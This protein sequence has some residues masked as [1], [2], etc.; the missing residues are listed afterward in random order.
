MRSLNYRSGTSSPAGVE[1]G[2]TFSDLRDRAEKVDSARSVAPEQISRLLQELQS[3]QEIRGM[4]MAALSDGDRI[5]AAASDVGRHNA[6]DK[7]WGY[8]LLHDVAAQ[9]QILL[10]TGRI[11]SEMLGKAARMGVPVVASRTSPTSLAVQLAVAWNVTLVGYV[12][13]ESMNV[14]A[15]ASRI[16]SAQDSLAPI[17]KNEEVRTNAN[18]R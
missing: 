3:D 15:G 4:H 8:C 9:D 16:A 12:R 6:V 14:Y 17:A 11:S 2:V 13:R 10:S 1:G 5:I 7:L 18:L